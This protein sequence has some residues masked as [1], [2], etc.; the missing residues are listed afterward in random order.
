LEKGLEQTLT[1]HPLGLFSKLR[2]NFKTTN[3]IENIIDQMGIYT[4]RLSYWENSDPRK[5]LA[6][7]ALQKIE[8]K[9][10][11]IRGYRHLKELR[12]DMKNLNL[13]ENTIKVV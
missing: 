5:R 13:K 10:Y 8:P 2:I 9:L 4:D 6:G 7:T 11:V 1:L 3:Y 12:E